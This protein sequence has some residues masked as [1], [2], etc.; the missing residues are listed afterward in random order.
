MQKSWKEKEMYSRILTLVVTLVILAQFDVYAGT[1]TQTDWS[2]GD[3]IWG[4]VFDWGDEFYLD[5][6]IECYSD[7]LI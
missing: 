2:G 6:D 1:A 4:P 3:G 7:P 5:T